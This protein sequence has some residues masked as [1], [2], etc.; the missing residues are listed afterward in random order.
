MAELCIRTAASADLAAIVDIQN[1]Y[2]THSHATFETEPVSLADKAGWFMGYGDGRYQMLVA[3]D[4]GRILGCAYS[5]RYR[6]RPAFD[7][8]VE[9]SIYLDPGRR[10][11]GI[12]TALYA[13]LFEL[14]AEQ[15]VH[16]A[17]AGIAL[18][19]PASI[20]LHQK[21]G[22]EEVGTFREYASKNGKWMSSTWYQRLMGGFVPG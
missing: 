15:N 16:L 21:F 17:V 12:G 22:F 20:A 11:H 19:N 13:R 7:T 2:I 4:A 5:S 18:P 1:Y 3:E 9:T 8:T 14:L 6:P 10:Q